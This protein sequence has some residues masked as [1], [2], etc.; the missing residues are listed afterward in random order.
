MQQWPDAKSLH[1]RS[2]TLAQDFFFTLGNDAE[3]IRLSEVYLTH[4]PDNTVLWYRMGLSKGL[5]GDEQG[6]IEAFRKTIGLVPE[7][8]KAR[9]NLGYLLLNQHQYSEALEH[10]EARFYAFPH[11]QWFFDR[12]KLPFW[13][14]EPLNGKTI[15][16][17]TEQGL[18]D[19][20]QFCRYVNV[21]AQQGAKVILLVHK[22]HCTLKTVLNS[23]EGLTALYQLRDGER[24]QLPATF[25]FHCP[26]MSVLKRVNF[27][28][29]KIPGQTPYLSAPTA[30]YSQWHDL[31][32]CSKALKVGLVWTTQTPVDGME[33]K[34]RHGTLAQSKKI[35][36]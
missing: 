17:W 36:H 10:Y 16:L 28:E 23:L 11:Y 33:L 12:V 31:R 18:G 27:N 1:N 7:H 15:L 14:G 2:V 21:L 9:L 13:Q 34:Q 25:D 26:L 3:I 32:T 35:F 19:T 22:G 4:Y 20:I 29:D 5:T 24:L 30:H 6:A 8:H